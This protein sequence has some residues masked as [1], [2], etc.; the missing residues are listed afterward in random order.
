MWDEPYLETCCRAALRRL[1]L[2]GSAG[3]P[4][5]EMD[6]ACLAR[7]ANR[8]FAARRP[9]GRFEI[10]LSGR[11]RHRREIGPVPD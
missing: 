5:D 6:S 7:L 9:D 10:T 4:A 3:R 2:S 1:L 8:G 11:D